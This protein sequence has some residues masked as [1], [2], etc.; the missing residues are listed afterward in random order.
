MVIVIGDVIQNAL[1]CDSSS[2]RQW[3]CSNNGNEQRNDCRMARVGRNVIAR[4]PLGDCLW[5]WELDDGNTAI[6][7]AADFTAAITPNPTRPKAEVGEARNQQRSGMDQQIGI[8]C[9]SRSK[10]DNGKAVCLALPSI[11]LPCLKR[12]KAG[13]NCGHPEHGSR[14]LLR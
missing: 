13:P 10:N 6:V 1:L 11:G 14:R 12:R 3:P 9:L 5:D 8:R 2:F 4:R 7:T